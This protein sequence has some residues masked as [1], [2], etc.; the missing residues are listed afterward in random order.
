MLELVV[1]ELVQIEQCC[2]VANPAAGEGAAGQ[3]A[4]A[5]PLHFID[6]RKTMQQG[7]YKSE[8]CLANR[9]T[10]PVALACLM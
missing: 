4:A 10:P 9:E 6:S 8:S 2:I 1:L 7:L 5:C 3:Q